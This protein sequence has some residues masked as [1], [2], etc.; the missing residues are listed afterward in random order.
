M[1][2]LAISILPQITRAKNDRLT[3]IVFPSVQNLPLI[4][5]DAKGLKLSPDVAEASYQ[6]VKSGVNPTLSLIWM[7]C[8]K[9]LSCVRS[10]LGGQPAAEDNVFEPV[11]L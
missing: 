4:V 10:L 1:A 11:L 9:Y 3:I 8:A 6:S 5:A 7:A 2:A